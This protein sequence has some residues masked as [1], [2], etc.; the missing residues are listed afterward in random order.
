M[1][2]TRI[3]LISFSPCGHTLMYG[4]QMANACAEALAL[5]GFEELNVTPLAAGAQER[6]FP[7]SELAPLCAVPKPN[8]YF[9]I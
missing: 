6:S 1:K 2:I 3:R 9:S 7:P 8:E 5:S 4:R